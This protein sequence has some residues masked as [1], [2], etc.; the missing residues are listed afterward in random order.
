MTKLI[1]LVDLDQVCADFDGRARSVCVENG[2]DLDH[3][4]PSEQTMRYLTDHVTLNH[5]RNQLRKH[6]DTTPFFADL[7]VIPGAAEGIKELSRKT[8]TWLCSKPLDANTSCASDKVAW[9]KHHFPKMHGRLILAPDKSLVHGDFL[10]DD[11]PKPKWFDRATWVPI[12]YTQ[13][14]NSHPES[15]LYNLPHYDWS[16][17]VDTLLK[18]AVEAIAKRKENA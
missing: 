5:H 10:L 6:I 14:F 9:V 1:A 16:M 12:V 15:D 2:W 18:L 11:A 3:D 13:P 17:P 7:D 8:E 4:H